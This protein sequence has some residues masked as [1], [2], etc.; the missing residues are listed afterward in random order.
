MFKFEI[1]LSEEEELPLGDLRLRKLGLRLDLVFLLGEWEE[2]VDG[3]MASFGFEFGSSN[4]LVHWIQVYNIIFEIIPLLAIVVILIQLYVH[5]SKPS[6]P[7]IMVLL[8]SGG[9]TG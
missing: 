3:S 8:G 4:D 6:K 7:S 1:Q 2:L 9:H 5:R